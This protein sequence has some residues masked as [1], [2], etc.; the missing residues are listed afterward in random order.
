VCLGICFGWNL[1]AQQ[2]ESVTDPNVGA[3]ISGTVAADRK[4]TARKDRAK[5]NRAADDA[6]IAGARLLEKADRAGAEREF[7]RASQLSPDN[8]DY[9]LALSAIRQSRV[10]ELVHQ[11]GAAR[12]LG[13]DAQAEALLAQ[14]RRIDP[15][16]PVL[17]QHPV[18]DSISS[19]EKVHSWLLDGPRLAQPIALKPAPGVKSFHIHSTLQEAVRQVAAAYGL[20]VSLDTSVPNAQVKFDLDD[21]AYAQAMHVLDNMGPL[22]EVALTP[23]MVFVAKDT[24]ENRQKYERQLQETIYA[25][26]MTNDQLAELGNMIKN[27]FEVKQ[28][29]V[30]NSFG[31]LVVRAPEETIRVLNLTLADMLDGGSEVMLDLKLYSVDKARTLNLGAVLPSQGGAYNVASAANALVQANQTVVNQAIAQG[32]IPAGTSNLEI[33]ALLLE[34]GLATS[35]LL[36]NTLAFV[37]GGL[38][39]TGVYSNASSTLN[40]ALNSSDT[41]ALDEIQLRVGDRQ[42]ATFRAGSKYPITQSTYSTTTAAST[43]GLAGATIGGVSVAS[44]LNQAATATTPQIQYEDLGVTLKATPTVQKSGLISIH[45]DLKIESLQGGT[46]DNIPILNNNAF[47]SDITVGDGQEAFLV[48]NLTKSQIAAVTGIPGLSELPGFQQSPEV[49]KTTDAA[50]LLMVLTPRIIRKRPN[51]SAGPRFSIATPATAS[52]D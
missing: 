33:A 2:P 26:G 40:I 42:S 39:T 11:A 31:T 16:S 19:P 7:A 36:S 48:S 38:T 50:Q 24:E 17:L 14:A 12:L 28:I 47:T 34:Y 45:L 9:A 29:T 52:A 32:I 6:F 22:F 46:V 21:V 5:D 1:D 3:A 49:D 44:L 51:D 25:A 35:S 30:A 43:A 27:V 4:D 13:R 23:E 41:R 20:K 37:G 15:D 8:R 10:S 18:P